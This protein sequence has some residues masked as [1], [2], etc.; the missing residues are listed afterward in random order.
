MTQEGYGIPYI[1]LS[2]L[3]NLWHRARNI[4]FGGNIYSNKDLFILLVRQEADRITIE[5]LKADREKLEAVLLD[6][7]IT[8]VNLANEKQK[9]IRDLKNKIEDQKYGD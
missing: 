3:R 4:Y 7:V 1:P 5:E 8:N 2:K 6:V 9:E